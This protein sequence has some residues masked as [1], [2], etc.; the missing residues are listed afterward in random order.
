MNKKYFRYFGGAMLS[1][2]K[3]LNKIANEGYRLVK[4]G[5][6]VYEFMPCVPGQYH[7]AVTF[8][9]EQSYGKTQS[10]KQFLEELGYVVHYKNINLNFSIGKICW[11]PYGKGM[12]QIATNPGN[13]NKELLIVEKQNDGQPF[14]LHST[15][16]DKAIYTKNL[17][18]AWLSVAVLSLGLGFFTYF[19]QGFSSWQWIFPMVMG[20]TLLVP[21]IIYQQQINR[22]YKENNLM[23]R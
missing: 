6:L 11:R 7:Y 5:K 13:Y 16:E 19:N 15:N 22:Y 14:D 4:A 21:V 8:V 18:N 9:A 12:G 3:W 17:R 2:E 10:Y 1:Q 23:E 20:G